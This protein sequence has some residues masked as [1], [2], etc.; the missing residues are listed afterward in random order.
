MCRPGDSASRHGSCAGSFAKTPHRNTGTPE[1]VRARYR[2]SWVFRA[3]VFKGPSCKGFVG[4]GDADP[5]NVSSR[6]HGSELRMAETRA[7]C[8]A[9]RKA[10]AV[11]CTSVEEV[12]AFSSPSRSAT[13]PSQSNRLSSHSSSGA[14][15]S[16]TPRSALPSDPPVQPGCK[17]CEE[18]CRGLLLH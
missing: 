2:T 9:L 18:L 6:M 11:G 13:T 15:K 7:T 14:G 5:S 8:R 1:F 17:S 12:S 4:Y 3:I 10:Y 16:P